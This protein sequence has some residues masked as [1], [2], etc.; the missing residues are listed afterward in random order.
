M[1]RRLSSFVTG[2][3]ELTTALAS[4]LGDRLRLGV[5][6]VQVGAWRRCFRLR[7][8]EMEQQQVGTLTCWCWPFRPTGP[9]VSRPLD[10]DLSEILAHIP[11]VFR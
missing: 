10:S 4:R 1:R 8:E 6:I 3:D 11:Y 5:R 2:L 9:A 7:V